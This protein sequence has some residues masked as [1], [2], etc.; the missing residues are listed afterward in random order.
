MWHKF[1]GLGLLGWL[2]EAIL[3]NKANQHFLISLGIG[4]N[5]LKPYLKGKYFNQKNLMG[6]F[7]SFLLEN[8]QYSSFGSIFREAI[9][10]TKLRAV[11]GTQCNNF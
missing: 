3:R 8:Q 5:P 9:K 2:S 7:S 11:A 4:F 6:I 10:T 1:C